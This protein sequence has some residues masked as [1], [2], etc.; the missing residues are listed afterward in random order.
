MASQ[1]ESVSIPPD[2]ERP[3]ARWGRALWSLGPLAA[4][5]WIITGGDPA[6]WGV[7][8][9]AVL[10]AAWALSRLGTGADVRL[11]MAGRPLRP[12]PP[13]VRLH[14]CLI[15][16]EPGLAAAGILVLSLYAAHHALVKG[17]LFLGVGLRQHAG[18]QGLVLAGSAVLALSLAG[19]PASSGAV[20]KY[21]IKPTLAHVDWPW[22]A[23]AV[24][25]STVGTA[26]LMVRFLW[27]T[28]RTQPHPAPG[29]ALGGVAWGALIALV[30]LYPLALGTPAAWAS[31][32]WPMGYVAE[33]HSIAT[34]LPCMAICPVR[35]GAS[36]QPT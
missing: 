35:P 29:Y 18:A 24:A 7:G 33:P 30:L 16:L 9:P 32:A 14:W 4:L 15:L 10:A 8:I 27:V 6:S 19:A 22:L 20:A 3:L 34:C 26:L 2:A 17:G 23:G 36:P 25:L 31:N 11:S 21:A 28:W 1:V 12:G 13:W 5:W